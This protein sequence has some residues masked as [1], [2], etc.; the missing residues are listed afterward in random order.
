MGSC[1][2]GGTSGKK[3]A[4]QCRRLKKRVWFDPWFGKFPGGGHSNPLQYS[5]LENPLDG[6]AWQATVHRLA[7]SDTTEAT[8]HTGMHV[9]FPGSCYRGSRHPEWCHKT[10]SSE[11]HAASQHQAAIALNCVYKYLCFISIYLCICEQHV[12]WG[13]CF[14]AFMPLWLTKTFIRHPAFA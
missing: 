3:P 12:S 6:K 11:L 1:F 2:P 4:C 13:N 9:C 14:S 7:E 8:Q 10:P 5:C